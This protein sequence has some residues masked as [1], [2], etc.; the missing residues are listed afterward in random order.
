MAS[1]TEELDPFVDFDLSDLG[2]ELTEATEATDRHT[3]L[4]YSRHRVGKT[5][6][7]STMAEVDGKWP[8]LWVACE[9]GTTAFAGKYPEGR[10][11][12]VNV[13]TWKEIEQLVYKLN[14]AADA[15]TSPFKTVVFDTIGE[16]QEIIK[17]DYL[18]ANKSSDFAMW[19]QV[20]DFPAWLMTNFQDKESPYNVVYIAHTEKVKDDTLGAVLL[21]PFFLGKKSIVDL[22]KVPDTIAYLAKAQDSD[23]ET[24]RVLQLTST[25][26]I[27]AGSRLEHRLPKQ[28]V[29]PTMGKFFD[30]LTGKTELPE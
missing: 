29:N 26:R 30:Y 17:R 28:I 3:M 22:P 25:D 21:S 6:L 15:G 5:T 18:K 9:D 8:I 7:A 19:A 20:A 14:E 4:L 2:L 23:G 24:V 27:D 16:M 12:V 11:K 1:K 10:I 13:R